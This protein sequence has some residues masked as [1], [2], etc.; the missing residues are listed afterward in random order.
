MATTHLQRAGR[1]KEKGSKK[2]G[3]WEKKHDQGKLYSTKKKFKKKREATEGPDK[4]GV[5]GKRRLTLAGGVRVGGEATDVS[6][7]NKVGQS[8]RPAS[9]VKRG[10][11]S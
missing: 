3:S 4:F 5:E 11:V 6:E 10:V 1:K 8:Y 9:G 7:N 2:R